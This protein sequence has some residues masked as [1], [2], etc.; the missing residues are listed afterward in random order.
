MEE[1]FDSLV[2]MIFIV[3]ALVAALNSKAKKAK[4]SAAQVSQHKQT[5]QP[6][7]RQLTTPK[8]AAAAQP[9]QKLQ[10][11]ASAPMQPR[12][13][14]TVSVSR[15]DHTGMFDG[16]MNAETLEGEDPFHDHGQRPVYMPSQHSDRIINRSL[17]E[18]EEEMAE[19]ERA[20]DLDW[21]DSRGLVKAFVMQEILT[22][23]SDRKR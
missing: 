14:T 13:Q 22:R 17:D 21:N 15:H 5:S 7:P 6:V 1:L 12:V 10:P 16:S 20:L 2:P 11:A 19:T 18:D 8:P 23:P 9:I 3:I 4:K